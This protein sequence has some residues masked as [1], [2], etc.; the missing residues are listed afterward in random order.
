ML[1]GVLSLPVLGLVLCYTRVISL[2]TRFWAETSLLNDNENPHTGK[3]EP[4]HGMKTRFHTRKNLNP[5]NEKAIPQNE[6]REPTHWKRG[7]TKWEP[8]QGV[9]RRSL[10]AA[11]RGVSESES[12]HTVCS[13]P[14]ALCRVACEVPLKVRT[15]TQRVLRRRLY[16]AWRVRCC[17]EALKL[18]VGYVLEFGSGFVMKP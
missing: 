9:F 6:K 14:Q 5:I 3:Q 18:N 15:H 8:T 7:S 17:C 2:F 1:C 10:C 12:P 4:T 13:P 16:A 11:W